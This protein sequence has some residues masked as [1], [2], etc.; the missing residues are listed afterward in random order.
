MKQYKLK[1][2]LIGLFVVIGSILTSCDYALPSVDDRLEEEVITFQHINPIT[3]EAETNVFEAAYQKSD[4][5]KLSF[6]TL[7]TVDRVSVVSS[8]TGE[9]LDDVT[10]NG[11]SASFEYLVEDLNIPFG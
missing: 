6:S 5:A 3:G 10:V 11:T 2:T 1:Y 4:M 9:L 8:A 7:K